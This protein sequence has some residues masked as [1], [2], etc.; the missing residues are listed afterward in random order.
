[1]TSKTMKAVH[2]PAV[3]QA[4]ELM[5]VPVPEPDNEQ[6]RIKVEACGVCHGEAKIV[7]GWASSYPRIP[8][9]EVV[10]VIDSV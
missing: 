3:G 7:D 10:G 1:M 8:G 2:V 6:V 5:S 4:L 9:H